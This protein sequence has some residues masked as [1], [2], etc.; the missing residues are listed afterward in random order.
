MSY[1]PFK[2]A[3]NYNTTQFPNI[4]LDVIMPLCSDQEWKVISALV[5][6]SAATFS[7]LQSIT[8]LDRWNLSKGIGEALERGI[9][10]WYYP[11]MPDNRLT[12]NYDFEIVETQEGGEDA[13]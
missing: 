4:V 8:G 2:E 1:K 11:P 10:R 3:D 9:V 6:V 12:L 13:Q 5:Y 7:R